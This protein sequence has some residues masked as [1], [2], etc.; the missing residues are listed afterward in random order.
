M[1]V[2]GLWIIAK[3]SGISIFSKYYREQGIGDD[4]FSGYMSAITSFLGELTTSQGKLE[5]VVSLGSQYSLATEDMKLSIRG[6]DNLIFVLVFDKG[7]DE[8]SMNR[9]LRRLGEVFRAMYGERINANK[10]SISQID[11]KNFEL[12]MDTLIGTLSKKIDE[13]RKKEKAKSKEP[14]RLP[15][16]VVADLDFIKGINVTVGNITRQG[17]DEKKDPG[18]PIEVSSFDRKVTV[19]VLFK[20][21][22]DQQL[23]DWAKLLVEVIHK[24][25][26]LPEVDR[27]RLALL[28]IDNCLSRN[29]KPTDKYTLQF[30]LYGSL[31]AHGIDEGLLTGSKNSAS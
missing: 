26:V 16:D 29:P 18:F 19:S 3:D 11:F 27:L 10:K 7:D 25:G 15:K 28:Y 23:F 22:L 8:E 17:F 12:V 5:K 4:L 20:R 2:R 14:Q 6:L 31:A 9:I 13:E 24:L 21:F 30:M 1:P